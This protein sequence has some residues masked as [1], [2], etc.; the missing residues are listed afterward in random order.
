MH[1][2]KARQIKTQIVCNLLDGFMSRDYKS[3]RSGCG[4]MESQ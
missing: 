3:Y 2:I 1:G 4:F